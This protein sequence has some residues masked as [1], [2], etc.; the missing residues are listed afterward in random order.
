MKILVVEDDFASR[1]VLQDHLN[2]LGVIH[3]AVDGSEALEAVRLA[4]KSGEHYQLICLDIM[5]PKLGGQDTLVEIRNIEQENGIS[6]AREAKV[7]MTTALD[8]L[9]DVTKAYSNLCDAYVTKPIRKAK[10]QETLTKLGLI[11][12]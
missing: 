12:D 2:G 9:T 1:L 3:T 7:V 4:L 5:M 8:D 6:P 11:R 10:L